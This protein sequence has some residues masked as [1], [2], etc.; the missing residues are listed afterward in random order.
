MRT[1]VDYAKHLRLF[2]EAG[3]DDLIADRFGQALH[4]HT[5]QL[6]VDSPRIG[7]EF[8]VVVDLEAAREPVFFA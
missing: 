3:G 5:L 8:A 4:G 1:A 6:L 2:G 7:S